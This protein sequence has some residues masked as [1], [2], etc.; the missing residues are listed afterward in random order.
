MARLFRLLLNVVVSIFALALLV[1]WLFYWL[2]SRSLPDY[3][4]QID[5][6]GINAPVEIARDN[7]NVPHIFGQTDADVYFGL[8][9]AHAQDRLFQMMLLRRTAQGKLSE[10]FGRRTFETDALMRRIGIYPAAEKAARVQTPQA[11]AALD[12]Y[13][14]GVNAWIT[15]VNEGAKGRG[16]PEL[17]FFP[18]EIAYWRAA[19]SIALLKLAAL[20]YSD[21]VADEVLR[22][23]ASLLL[24]TE[25]L[26]DLMPDAPG[27]GTALLPRY[28]A[29]FPEIAPNRHGP[30]NQTRQTHLSPLS[31][32]GMAGASNV[33]A[34]APG[35]SAS[36]ASL[37]ANDPH[38][39][40]SAPGVWYLAR[41]EL[42]NGGLIGAT[43][44][45]I[46]AVVSGRRAA[47]GWGITAAYVD[48][49]D[50]H[51]EK[52][53]PDA[54]NEVLTPSGYVPLGTRPSIIR[55]KDADPVTIV[56]QHTPNGPVLPGDAFDLK[57]IT[58][59]GHLASLSW[60]GLDPADRSI[61]A[62]IALNHAHT[63]SEARRATRDYVAPAVNLLLTESD[64]STMVVAGAAP[65]R[66]PRHQSQG[67]I[68]APGWRAENLWQGMRAPEDLPSFDSGRNG[69]LGNTNNK[70]VDAPFPNHLSYHW[71]DTQRIERWRRLMQ[72]REVHTRESFIEIQNDIVSYSARAI[73]PLVGADL[74]FT[75]EAAPEGTPERRRQ[76]ALRLLAEWNG[77]MNEHLPEPLIYSAWM[78]HL[79]ERLIRDE[80]GPLSQ[81]FTH[82]EPL[83]LE[84]VYRDIEGASV[85]C[86]VIQSAAKETC[87]DI[88]R[89]ALDDAL[90][91][92]DEAYGGNLE[93]LRWGDAH[94]ARHD[95]PVLGKTAFINWV[96]NIR[97]ST[98]GGDHT[99]MRGVTSGAGPNPFA[100]VHAAAYRGVYDFADPDSSVFIISTGQSGHPLSR[101]YDD[102][103]ELWRR[104][105]YVPMSLDPELARAAGVG[106]T[107]L[108]PDAAE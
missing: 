51:I 21:Q 22:A 33:W 104:G 27:T 53:N 89:L 30:F 11:Q 88:A 70:T 82:V 96:V 80:I 40:L 100:N 87:Q 61:S 54:P 15:E 102:L 58:P 16:A 41:L 31:A 18:S 44:P 91:W 85:W 19:D 86:D 60:T 25:R 93:S 83:F 108:Y 34:S 69:V 63:I 66:D 8:G 38:L 77:E 68:P 71:G 49:A 56:V 10:V 55:I 52:L 26:A 37:L 81:A 42:E 45:G 78:Q 99:L 101:H 79:Q 13:A 36:G 107:M 76:D 59:P 2:A 39:G 73:L 3:D 17:F 106:V 90:I 46:P 9:F 43:I 84:R 35:R 92:I 75:G 74:W 97:Q 72:A 64:R 105:E 67:R 6:V 98:S 28:A 65:K 7:V 12:A 48:D 50:V 32:R 94:V 1:S 5:V 95:H 103:G 47:F 62:L 23:Q 14:R 4:A 29:L 20:Q 57:R 24:P